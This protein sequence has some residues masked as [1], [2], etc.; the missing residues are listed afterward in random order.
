MRGVKTRHVFK[1]AI[2]FVDWCSVYAEPACAR[3]ETLES[4]KEIA[5]ELNREINIDPE[6]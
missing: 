1:F 6:D 5:Q 2:S 4:F 3:A